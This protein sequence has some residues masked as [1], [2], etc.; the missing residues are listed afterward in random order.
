MTHTE[1]R[2]CGKYH[3]GL[4]TVV[5][6]ARITV[7]MRDAL[8]AQADAVGQTISERIEWLIETQ[9]LRKR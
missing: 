2:R 8:K 4:P 7:E 9:A 6:A 1:A 5:V 3:T